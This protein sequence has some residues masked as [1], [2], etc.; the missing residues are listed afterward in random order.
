MS[1]SNEQTAKILGRLRRPV[2]RGASSRPSSSRRKFFSTVPARRSRRTFVLTDPE[3]HELCLRPDSH[4]G[5]PNALVRRQEI[6]RPACLSW[7]CVPLS[8]GRAGAAESILQT[9]VECMGV[10]D[11]KA[12]D[13]EVLSLAVEGVR[14]AGLKSFSLKMA[15]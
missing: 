4:S 13:I 10:G 3:G 9:G 14:A 8:T 2:L 15:I 12:A 6:S 11:R 5:L 1:G 7:A